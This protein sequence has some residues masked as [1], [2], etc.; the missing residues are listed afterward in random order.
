MERRYFSDIGAGGC[1]TNEFSLRTIAENFIGWWLGKKWTS[2]GYVFDIGQRTLVS[3]NDLRRILEVED[4]DALELLHLEANPNTNGNGSLMRTLP[5]YF[6]LKDKGIEENF[7]TIWQV[8]ALTHPHIRAALACFVYLIMIDELTKQDS[9]KVAYEATQ[10]RTK[11]FFEE[12]DIDKEEAGHFDRLIEF[13]ISLLPREEISSAGYVIDTLEASFWAFLT[14]DSYETAILK[15]VNLGRD[16]DTVGSVTGGMAG[17]FYGI[18]TAPKQW[19][20]AVA[21]RDE[22]EALCD[23]LS[24]QYN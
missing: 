16:T 11:R 24:K 10:K 22:I 4:Y 1:L 14:T 18:D 19:Y 2:H 23:R 21:K 20:Q 15:V 9:I 3:F 12:N 6:Y 13:D 5:L 7:E 17:I 8:S